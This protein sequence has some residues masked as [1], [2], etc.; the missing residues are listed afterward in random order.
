M[1]L[2]IT[3][4]NRRVDERR[5]YKKKCIFRYDLVLEKN[6]NTADLSPV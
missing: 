2:N 4:S 6:F 3:F 5:T 1:R